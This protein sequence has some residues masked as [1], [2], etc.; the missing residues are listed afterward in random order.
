METLAI[1]IISVCCAVIGAIMGI[2][3]YKRNR[4]KEIK[5]DTAEQ[6]KMNAKLDAILSNNAKSESLVKELSDKFDSFKD[7]FNTRLVRVEES[8]K[9]AHTRIDK[10]TTKKK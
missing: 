3:T 6:I 8:C 2:S 5:T 9:F 7:D 10:L 4:D 1:S